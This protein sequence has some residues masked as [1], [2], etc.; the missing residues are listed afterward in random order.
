MITLAADY[1]LL[2]FLAACGVIQIVAAHS[3]LFGLLFVPRVQAGYAI[4]AGLLAG[5]FTWFVLTGDPNV[6][7]DL[8]GVEG[9]E[10]FG[11]FLGG[12]AAGTIVT[13]GLSSVTQLRL[14]RSDPSEPPRALG[15]N[16]TRG[17]EAL[18]H[19]TAL[20]AIRTRLRR[21]RGRA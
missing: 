14:G 5:S 8:G 2:V 12:T 21:S 15:T 6:P 18:R 20:A 17:F 11:L 13:L 10:Q 7:G 4:G 16:E 9:A 19:Q 3:R 1:F